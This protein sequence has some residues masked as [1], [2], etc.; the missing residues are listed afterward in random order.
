VTERAR[1]ATTALLLPAYDEAVLAKQA[2]VV[3]QVSGGRLD[4][5]VGLGARA[6]D[7]EVFGRPFAAR[8]RRLSEQ[9]RRLHALWAPRSRARRTA[10]RPVRPRRSGPAHRC[11][12]AATPTPRSAGRSASATPTCS[13]RRASRPSPPAC[14]R[15]GRPPSGPAVR[16]SR[17]ARSP[18]WRSTPTPVSWPRGSGC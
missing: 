2:A 6:D 18:T 10:A 8:G 4:L 17:S 5:G 7:Y 15:S 12:S 13:A 3:D 1:L 14:R 11:G 16:G 9:L